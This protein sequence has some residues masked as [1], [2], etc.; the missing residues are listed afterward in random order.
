M[1]RMA[2]RL[3]LAAAAL[4]LSAPALAQTEQVRIDPEGA[5]RA[6]LLLER[7]PRFEAPQFERGLEVPVV[8]MTWRERDAQ[9]VIDAVGAT[10]TVMLNGD[11]PDRMPDQMDAALKEALFG[12]EGGT[13]TRIPAAPQILVKYD[14]SFDEFRLINEEL[15][16]IREP[17]GRIGIEDA[18]ARAERILR[19][20]IE[21]KVVDAELYRDAAM[22]LGYRR[23][24]RGT[25]E[26]RADLGQIVEYRFTYRPR[27][28]GIELA[29][30]GVRIG[31]LTDGAVSSM[32]VGGV[33]PSGTFREGRLRP[34]DGGTRRDIEIAPG[35]LMT[36]FYRALPPN[37]APE[38]AWSKVM[39]AMPDDARSALVEPQLLISFSERQPTD[40]GQWVTSRRRVLGFSLVD[41]EASPFDY[42][43]ATGR[44][45]D[46]PR[47]QQ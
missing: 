19:G 37:A 9:E 8:R 47:R 32:R 40:E 39:Y 31:L 2:T 41:P 24:G 35:E 23:V 30:A 21:R 45:G 10:V 42:T 11:A 43:A 26:G 22:Q 29:N 13:W 18:Q 6:P 16:V 7:N 44:G 20:L 34:E 15:D 27:I 36:R 12:N 1:F 33:T 5:R 25:T 28:E 3:S 4:A 46:E 17:V 38:I 14:R